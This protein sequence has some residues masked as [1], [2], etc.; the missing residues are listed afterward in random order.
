MREPPVDRPNTIGDRTRHE[1]HVAVERVGLSHVVTRLD[2]A[3]AQR[4]PTT[5][6]DS[7]VRHGARVRVGERTDNDRLRTS[8]RNGEQTIHGASVERYVVVQ[9]QKEL[10][11]IAGGV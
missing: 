10:W 4:M 11:A 2:Q 1:N 9:P 5:Q 3:E 7:G 8:A 6:H